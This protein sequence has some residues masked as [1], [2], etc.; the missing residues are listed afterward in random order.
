ME[1]ADSYEGKSLYD[2][3]PVYVD[4]ITALPRVLELKRTVIVEKQDKSGEDYAII[5]TPVTDSEGNIEYVIE[6]IYDDR[7]T[8]DETADYFSGAD[9]TADSMVFI[10]P[11]M[12]VQEI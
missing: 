4:R 6:A 11:R 5:T 10:S 12:H 8:S 7:R 3:D 1:G 2:T 9:R